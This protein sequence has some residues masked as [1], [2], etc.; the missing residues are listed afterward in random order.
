MSDFL[1][2]FM[3]KILNIRDEKQG[4]NYVDVEKKNIFPKVMQNASF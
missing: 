2:I 1:C 3:L 4:S